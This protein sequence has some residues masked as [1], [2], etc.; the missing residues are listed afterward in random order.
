MLTFKQNRI[1][2]YVHYTSIHE[3]KKP[4]KCD[5]CDA[6]FSVKYK[7]KTHYVHEGNKPYECDI[8]SATFALR[9][10]LKGHSALVHEG[11]KPF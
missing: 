4:F 9:D 5:I 6:T 8:Y 2:K 11:N 3:G 7:L 1:W 10:S